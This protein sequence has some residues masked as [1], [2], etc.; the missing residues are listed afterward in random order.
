MQF[1]HD[2]GIFILDIESGKALRQEFDQGFQLLR[3]V[4]DREIG[5]AVRAQETAMEVG[6]PI[7]ALVRFCEIG[8]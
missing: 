4:S 1:L 7:V 8:C 6:E 3:A 5:W 2:S